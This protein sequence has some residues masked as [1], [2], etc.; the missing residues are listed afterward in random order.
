[1]LQDNITH[2]SGHSNIRCRLEEQSARGEEATEPRERKRWSTA[3][4]Q[5]ENIPMRTMLH[6]SCPGAFFLLMICPASTLL[7]DAQTILKCMCWPTGLDLDLGATCNCH[8]CLPH[9]LS[10]NSLTA[11]LN[12]YD[13]PHNFLAKVVRFWNFAF[14]GKL[15]SLTCPHSSVLSFDRYATAF[16]SASFSRGQ[17][18]ERAE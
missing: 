6:L 1:M 16:H 3:F 5:D 18:C 15:W 12:C 17:G 7:L 9:I 14:A 10:V 13:T 8:A 4:K 2:H 11:S